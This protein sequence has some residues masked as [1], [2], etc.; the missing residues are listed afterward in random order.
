MYTLDK[1]IQSKFQ[2]LGFQLLA[3][4]KRNL[5]FV[6]KMKGIWWIWIWAPNILKNLHFDWFLLCKVHNVWP[7]KVQRSIFHD[8]RTIQNLK[9][10]WLVVWKW[11][12]E[13]SKCSTE[14]LKMSKLVSWDPFVHSRKCMSY[15]LHEPQRSYK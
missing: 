4:L 11:H 13:F 7:K 14:H 12:E 2:F 8:K 10:I 9:K 1:R 3:Y 15:K 6:S 5:F